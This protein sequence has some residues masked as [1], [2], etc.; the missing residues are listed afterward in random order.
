MYVCII[1]IY[2]YTY[3]HTNI[4][5][6]YIYVCM[7][8]YVRTYVRTYVCMYNMYVLMLVLRDFDRHRTDKGGGIS[9]FP[10]PSKKTN[11]LYRALNSM[12]LG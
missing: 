9:S 7:Y 2:I 11:A 4:M 10:V 5:F 6:I 12:V 8:M 3:T 1:Y